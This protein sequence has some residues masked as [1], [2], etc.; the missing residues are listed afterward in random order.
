M[1][2]N[3]HIFSHS[4]KMYQG[5]NVYEWKKRQTDRYIERERL[6]DIYIYIDTQGGKE[7]H[8][9]ERDRGTLKRETEKR[10]KEMGKKDQRRWGKRIK[11]VYIISIYSIHLRKRGKVFL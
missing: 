11:L 8:E 2:T 6:K 10:V 3:F 7:R 5:C 9:N 1:I 4:W